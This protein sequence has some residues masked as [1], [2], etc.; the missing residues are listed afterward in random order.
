MTLELKKTVWGRGHENANHHWSHHNFNFC[1]G[2]NWECVNAPPPP[3]SFSV[4]CLTFSTLFFTLTLVLT[5]GSAVKGCTVNTF[6][7]TQHFRE[8]DSCVYFCWLQ[9]FLDILQHHQCS[10][11]PKGLLINKSGL[12]PWSNEL[13]VFVEVTDV[14][15][16]MQ[17]RL[18][19][20]SVGDFGTF[21]FYCAV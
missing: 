4:R 5:K 8:P 16:R 14:I 18:D 2:I 17:M 19:S 11:V 3:S 15:H 7:S 21:K 20:G 9:R 10:V 13:F 6:T 12:K 1:R